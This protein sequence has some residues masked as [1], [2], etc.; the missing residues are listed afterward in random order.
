[1]E[2]VF[3]AH[4]E[5]VGSAHEFGVDFAASPEEAVDGSSGT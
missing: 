3:R 5:D 4:T 1:M 2:G